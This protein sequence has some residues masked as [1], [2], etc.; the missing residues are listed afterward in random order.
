M[1]TVIFVSIFQGVMQEELD[2]N[3]RKQEAFHRELA[4]L[5]KGYLCLCVIDGIPYLYRKHREG[6]RI[7]SEYIGKPD[8]PKSLEAKRH[9]EAYLL[10]KNSLKE[11]RIEEKRLRKA[12]K[13]YAGL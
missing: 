10:A 7:V 12:I 9:R 8:D 1:N 2:R 4:S 5:P 13:D 11:L 6:K 3:L